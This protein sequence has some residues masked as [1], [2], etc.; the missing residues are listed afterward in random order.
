MKMAYWLI[1][2]P[3]IGVHFGQIMSRK[4]DTKVYFNWWLLLNEFCKADCQVR[5]GIKSQIAV[6]KEW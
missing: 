1:H 2:R 5:E 4:T 3:I 6:K